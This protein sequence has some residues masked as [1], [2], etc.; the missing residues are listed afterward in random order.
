M[1]LGSAIVSEVL[2]TLLLHASEGFTRPLAAV[3]VLV[4][5][6]GAILLFSRALDH[7]LALGIAYGTLTGCGLVAAT[8]LSTVVF[9]DPIALLQVVG[10]VLILLGALA[11][12]VPVRGGRHA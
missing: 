8:V 4:G 2:G 5:Y 10:L 12:N 3:G 6:C 7:G 9:G 11:L 1:L